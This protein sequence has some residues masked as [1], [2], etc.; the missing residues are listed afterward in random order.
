MKIG[1][2]F[3][4]VLFDT[5]SFNDYLK[6][7]TGLH[8]VD[9]D[10]YD[11]HGCYSP[12]KHAEASGIDVEEVYGAMKNLNQFLY[13]DIDELR[14][15]RNN[16]ELVIVTRGEE[17]LQKK[18]VKNSGAERLFDKLFVVQEGSKEVGDIDF[19]VDDRKKE[20]ERVSVPGMVFDRD[21][22]RLKDVINT[23]EEE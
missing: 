3:D 17:K 6:E 1:F 8:Y 20:I 9:A 16:H 2:D 15:L 4:R 10:V 11:E 19:L 13:K 18:K 14:K 5:D 22:H 7:K 23:I 21:K 12:E